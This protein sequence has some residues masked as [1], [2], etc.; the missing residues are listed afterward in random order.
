MKIENFLNIYPKANTKSVYRAGIFDFL[1]CINGERVREGVRATKEEKEK[2]EQIADNYFIEGRDYMGDMLK[3]AAYMHGQPPT[4]AR[5]KFSGVKE[6]L[7]HYGVEF[8]QRQLRQL[9]TK[10][11]H[12]KTSRTAEKDFSVEIIKKI[13]S[14]MSLVGK[15]VVLLLA[16]SGM[17]IGELLKIDIEDIDLTTIP[18]Q[19]VIRGENTK[20]GET[21]TVFISAEAKESVD[22]WLKVREA[23]LRS[24]LKRNAGLVEKAKAKK[25]DEAD[26]RLLPFSDSNMREIWL[27]ALKKAGLWS[28]DNSTQRSQY[29]I[30]GLRKFFRSQLA[31]SCPIDIVEALMG[32][33][34]YLTG[35]Y[36]RYTV[37]Q[38]SEFYLKGEGYISITGSGDIKEI[39]DRLQDTEAALDNYRSTISSQS[40]TTAEILNKFEKVEAE[41]KAL[42]E[43]I[44]RLED[45]KV[46]ILSDLQTHSEIRHV[47]E[48]AGK[49]F[50]DMFCGIFETAENDT[51]LKEK[52][53]AVIAAIR[54]ALPPREGRQ[55]CIEDIE[56]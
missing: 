51:E 21:R 48:T 43:R 36:R 35:A 50:L 5:A 4:G 9:S 22:E 11:P 46:S 53:D 17:R 15:T 13:L 23:Y 47:N 12:G 7:G 32:H 39:K 6:F 44:E 40:E 38:M 33:E 56:E 19:I 3:F 34:G 37:K 14:H 30:H 41:N 31:L 29:R 55:L 24:S 26:T 28:K 45:W 10:L 20:N 27:N 42:Y 49:G 25:K 16:S 2:Y 52:L 1:D 18:A 8:S 54:E